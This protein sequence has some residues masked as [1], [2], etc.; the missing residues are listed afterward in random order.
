M[1]EP[2]YGFQVPLFEAAE[3]GNDDC[4]RLL[5]DAGA[6]PTFG[7]GGVL[8][9]ARSPETFAILLAAGADPLAKPEIGFSLANVIAENEGVPLSDRVAM[10]RALR[11]AGAD[12]NEVDEN[13]LV[14]KEWRATPLFIAA[15]QHDADAVSA[16]FAAG[17]DPQRKPTALE[18]VCF[19]FATDPTDAVERIIDEC[20][21]AG[22]DINVPDANGYLPLH[23][24]L[25]PD[26]Y[27]P[28][29]SSS[30]GCNGSAAIA[31]I[32]NGA[33]FDVPYPGI[34]PGWMPLHVAAVQKLIPVI[35][36]LSAAGADKSVRN[37][38]GD[39]YLDIL[40]RR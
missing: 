2:Q 5:L 36:A 14:R 3:S 13:D 12:L 17:A 10:L 37:P 4:V 40:R 11:A 20:V 9:C 24:A 8:G 21:E 22:I 6:D 28:G 27:G 34:Y 26:A 33:R 30:D 25:S 19:S 31:L 38:D 29:Y 18:G 35:E 1:T 16:L 32:R 15:M 39:T 7:P 23:Q